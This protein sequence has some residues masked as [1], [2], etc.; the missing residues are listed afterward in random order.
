MIEI[1]KIVMGAVFGLL[2]VLAGITLWKIHTDTKQPS[3]LDL[4][5]STD[6]KGKVRFDARKCFEAGAFATST[7]AFVFITIDGKLTEWFFAGYMAAWV[8][9][10]WLRDREQRLSTQEKP[11]G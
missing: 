11:R 5:T 9:A 2:M 3:L 1:P 10:R 7:W 6:K 8:G 4:L